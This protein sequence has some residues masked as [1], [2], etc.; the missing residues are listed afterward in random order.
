MKKILSI[1][2]GLI[3][4]SNLSAQEDKKIR[5]GLSAT[6]SVNWY[7]T[8]LATVSHNG[9]GIG[10][11]W[12]LDLEYKLS[13]NASLFMGL[14]LANDN[15]KLAFREQ[16]SLI[17]RLDNQKNFSDDAANTT[18]MLLER[19][20]KANYVSLPLGIKMKTNEIGYMT[21]F[22]QF[23]LISSIR[24]KAKS[25]DQVKVNLTDE[26]PN[27]KLNIDND[28][29]LVKLQLSVGGGAEYN[30]SGTTSLVFGINYNLGFTNVLKKNSKHL[31]YLGSGENF[32][33]SATAH[34]IALSIGI[35]F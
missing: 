1:V 33:Q 15:G 8:D 20:Y 9:L 28:M 10:F 19:N 13:N 21:Y 3:F 6:P 30:L 17:Y 4:I 11:N 26:L 25:N 35:L 14:K 7:K 12:G 22:G 18:Y 27:P 31:T 5:F 34:N 16:D 29:Q 32:K 24:T 2:V 23:G